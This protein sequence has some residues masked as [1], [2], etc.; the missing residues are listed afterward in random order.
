MID[1]SLSTTGSWRAVHLLDSP[2]SPT[3]ASVRRRVAS[4]PR[5]KR[6][7]RVLLPPGVL[8]ATMRGVD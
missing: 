4:G 3:L 2:D 1:P 7:V 8:R 5:G 6:L